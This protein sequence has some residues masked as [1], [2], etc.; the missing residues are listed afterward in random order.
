RPRRRPSPPGAG[1]APTTSPATTTASCRRSPGSGGGELEHQPVHRGVVVVGVR[2][3]ALD[4]GH[5]GPAQIGQQLDRAAGLEHAG[6]VA[7]P[8]GVGD[9][10][11]GVVAVFAG[12]PLAPPPC[13]GAADPPGPTPPPPPPPPVGD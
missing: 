4:H 12:P 6:D 9:D 10:P 1:T 3:D 2:V 7:V 11:V 13:G 5:A 8:E